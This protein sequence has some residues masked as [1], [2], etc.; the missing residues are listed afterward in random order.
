MNNELYNNYLKS[1]KQKYNAICLDIDGTITDKDTNTINSKVIEKIAYVL[2]K[3]I[4]VVFITGR[5]ETGIISLKNQI[6]PMLINDYNVNH[7][8]LMNMFALI[9]DGARLCTFDSQSNDFFGKIQYIS[10]YDEINK[11]NIFN[12]KISKYFNDFNMNEYCKISYSYDSQNNNIINI[13]LILL[14]EDEN[15]IRKI[16]EQLNNLLSNNIFSCLNIT[17]GIY[18]NNIVFQIGTA[19]KEVAIEKTEKILGIPKDSMLRV[20][21]CGNKDGNDFSMLDCPQ[22]F[23]V[24][25]ISGSNVHC[26]PIFDENG[27]ILKGVEATIYLLTKIKLIKTIRLEKADR[28][29]YIKEYS[30]VVN[31]LKLR[32]NESLIKFNEIINNNFNLYGGI[33]DLFDKQ[34]G[35]IKIPMEE[36]ELIDDENPLKK[37]WSMTDDF[38]DTIIEKE[39]RN[40]YTDFE[41]EFNL[42][43]SMRDNDNYLLRGSRNYYYFMAMRKSVLNLETNKEDDFTSY[44]NIIGWYNQFHRFLKNSQEAIEKT[45]NF[46]DISNK[47]MI[48]GILDNIRNYI[49]I[50]MNYQIMREYNQKNVLINLDK[51]ANNSLLH[52]LYTKLLFIESSLANICFLKDYKIDKNELNKFILDLLKV[53]ILDS[54]TFKNIKTH[55]SKNHS[56]LFRTYREIDNFAE[57]YIT[58]ANT[59]KNDGEPYSICGMCYGGIEL[60][61][62]YKVLDIN[63]SNSD[64][65]LMNFNSASSGYKNKQNIDLRFFDINECGGIDQIGVDKNKKCIIYDDNAM[66]GKT[67]QIAINTLYDL[68]IDVDSSVVVK[69]PGINRVDQMFM[70]NHSAIDYMCFS[71]YIKGLYFSCP[72]SWRDS[73]GTDMYKD[74]FDI[75]DLNRRKI[76]ECLF[77]NHNYAKDSEIEQLNGFIAKNQDLGKDL[78]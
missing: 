47:K 1:L 34:S 48:L 73:L 2:K 39:I 11:L 40:E 5:G 10:T 59:I 46:D 54:E 21:D 76:A 72:Y 61:I 24:D 30:S 67:I 74:S 55:E 27:N 56:K 50:S 12:D 35:S 15:I 8:S 32:N 49:L 63:T 44:K 70:K 77:K 37:L 62:L 9:N 31:K 7:N 66:T 58:V 71:E 75:F 26:F 3:G 19:K 41:R 22:G 17:M 51:L 64:I 38:L 57:N 78:K 36:W 28:E 43:Y 53:L 14:T 23:S 45:N 69:Y 68:G 52:I 16:Y 6:I 25:R 33:Y 13:R 29:K 60:P 42:G 18:N 20:G 65:L 4:P